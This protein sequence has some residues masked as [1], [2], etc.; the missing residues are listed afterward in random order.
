MP[1]RKVGEASDMALDEVLTRLDLVEVLPAAE[2]AGGVPDVARSAIPE[3]SH[4][5]YGNLVN[6]HKDLP[7]ERDCTLP[8]W[9]TARARLGWSDKSSDLKRTPAPLRKSQC[10]A[11]RRLTA[12]FVPSEPS[13]TWRNARVWIAP[14]PLT[15]PAAARHAGDRLLSVGDLCAKRGHWRLA[16]YD[17][18]AD[19][20]LLDEDLVIESPQPDG[21]EEGGARAKKP[22]NGVPA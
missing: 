21:Q 4:G 10:P 19:G 12:L 11:Y 14:V 17:V 18:V 9:V 8:E 15:L 16:T 1:V 13:H 22:R 6:R 7:R 5:L 2:S 20:E 3:L